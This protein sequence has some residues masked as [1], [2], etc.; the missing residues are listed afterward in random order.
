MNCSRKDRVVVMVPIVKLPSI[1]SN[2]L[3]LFVACLLPLLISSAVQAQD[4]E[5]IRSAWNSFR[6]SQLSCI[7]SKL[8]DSDVTIEQLMDIGIGP[9]DSRFSDIVVGCNTIA[10]ENLK[11]NFECT[12]NNEEATIL[13]WCDQE[14]ALLDPDG[15]YRFLAIEDA[16][17]AVP[18]N[19]RR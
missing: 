16:R 17:R 1:F 14:F 18:D 4:Y 19:H 2:Y 10:V 11:Q 7:N 12:I 13:S 5:A 3:P 6:A 15:H 9:D 8:Q